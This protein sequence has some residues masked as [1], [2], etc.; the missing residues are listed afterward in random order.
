LKRKTNDVIK[1]AR[2]NTATAPLSPQIA[3]AGKR[4]ISKAVKE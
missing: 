3:A 1:I 2:A 4:T